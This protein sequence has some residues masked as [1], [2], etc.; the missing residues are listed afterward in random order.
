ML[1]TV[2]TISPSES[3]ALGYNAVFRVPPGGGKL[4]LVVAPD[5]F[6]SNLNGFYFITRSPLRQ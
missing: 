6:A 5:E 3:T 2:S 4:E 1:T